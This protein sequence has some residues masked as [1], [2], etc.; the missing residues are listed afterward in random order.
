MGTPGQRSDGPASRTYVYQPTC[1][2]QSARAEVLL[3]RTTAQDSLMDAGTDLTRGC[4]DTL[5]LLGI[6]SKA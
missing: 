3:P 5:L 4:V 2:D 6:A 1:P